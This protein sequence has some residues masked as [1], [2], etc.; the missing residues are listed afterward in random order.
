MPPRAMSRMSLATAEAV[1]LGAGAAADQQQV[2]GKIA[3]DGHAVGDAGDLG[4]GRVLGH[5]GRVHALLDAAL[6]HERDAEQLD[7]V[8]EVVGGLDVGL[9]DALDAL[10]VDLVEGDAGAERQARQQRQLVRGVEAA[11]VEGGV[12]FGVAL[13]PAP[14]SARRRRS[15]APPASCVRM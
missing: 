11:D 3:V 1:A 8:A 9:R 2:A 13:A 7:A 10:D 6:G 14:P 15:G 12:G 4:D 5:H